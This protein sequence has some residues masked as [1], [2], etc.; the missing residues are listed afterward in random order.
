MSR[1][2]FEYGKCNIRRA[3]RRAHAALQSDT[4]LHWRKVVKYLKGKGKGKKSVLI[5]EM[6][7]MENEI[8]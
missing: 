7:L 5:R 2:D 4:T 8:V 1:D 3:T 6:P